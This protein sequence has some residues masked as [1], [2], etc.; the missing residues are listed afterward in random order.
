MIIPLLSP[1][2]ASAEAIRDDT[3]DIEP[4]RIARITMKR[5]E[6]RLIKTTA[7]AGRFI[8]ENIKHLP[9]TAI[10]LLSYDTLN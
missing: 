10:L 4:Q 3:Y 8:L 6:I 9:I 7:F 2:H 5:S 1:P